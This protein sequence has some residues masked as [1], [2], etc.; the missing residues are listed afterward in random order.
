M[1]S[2]IISLY[3]FFFILIF[4]IIFS[5]D[6]L[7]KKYVVNLELGYTYKISA[8]QNFKLKES[9]Y[10]KILDDILL[11]DKKKK[12][13]DR[14]SI[15][16]VKNFSTIKVIKNYTVKNPKTIIKFNLHLKK[17][18]EP[19]QLEK[20]LNEKYFNSIKEVLNNIEENKSLFDYNDLNKEYQDLKSK[21]IDKIYFKLINS[22]FYK[23]FTPT[24]C[25][26]EIKK[27]CLK[28]YLNYHKYV[29][30]QIKINSSRD[31]LL[32]FFKLSDSD[33]INLSELV[34]EYYSNIMILDTYNLLTEEDG[35]NELKLEFFSKK[36]Q[37]FIKSKFF[38]SYVSDPE[39]YCRTYREGCFRVIS[40]HFNTVLYKHKIELE[41]KFNVKLIK[42][43]ESNF[44]NE[45]PK[46]IGLAIFLNY[47]LFIF[48]NRFFRKKLR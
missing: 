46:I 11:I 22:E 33:E 9:N 47:I 12:I 8:T 25:N 4:I 7:Y 39:N 10:N 43:E 28:I 32:K 36:Y 21:E 23:K 38:E 27:T 26:L 15:Y 31:D 48:T 5:I 41:N 24:K 13:S 34:Q 40:D 45:I 16:E 3:T 14:D 2:K 6:F 20:E 18:I 35:D 37:K 1:N 17:K 29:L 19:N 44:I 30:D 42:S